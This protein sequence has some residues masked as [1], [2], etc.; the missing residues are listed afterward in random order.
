MPIYEYLC[1]T[2]GNRFEVRQ[3]FADDALTECTEC[4][5]PVRRVLHPAGVIFKGSG[6][7]INDSRKSESKASNSDGGGE[8]GDSGAIDKNKAPKDATS[9]ESK[10]TESKPADSKKEPA[11]TAA[12]D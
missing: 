2:C 9:S 6:W 10:S 12:S 11:A 8:A 1:K 4:G 7:Y 3:N 5:A